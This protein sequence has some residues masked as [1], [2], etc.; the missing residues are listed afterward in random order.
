MALFACLVLLKDSK[1]LFDIYLGKLWPWVA[2][3]ITL[4]YNKILQEMNA[5]TKKQTL[6]NKKHASWEESPSKLNIMV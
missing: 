2:N 1:K 4:S 6:Q 3:D 5:E